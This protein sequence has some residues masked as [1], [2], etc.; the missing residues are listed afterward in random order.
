MWVWTARRSLEEV[1]D[2]FD[3]GGNDRECCLIDKLPQ[4]LIASIKLMVSQCKGIEAYR[5]HHLCIGF[6]LAVKFE[7]QF[8]RIDV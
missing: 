6:A 2:R 5:I 4:H 7:I 1:F 8:G 3:I